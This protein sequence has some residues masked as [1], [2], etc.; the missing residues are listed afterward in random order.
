MIIGNSESVL[1]RVGAIGATVRL[2]ILGAILVELIDRHSSLRSES[3]GGKG[4]SLSIVAHRHDVRTAQQTYLLY[5]AATPCA[6]T[7]K[8]AQCH[9]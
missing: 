9:N 5:P 7:G 8:S 1:H 4:I 2:A 3:E 6:R